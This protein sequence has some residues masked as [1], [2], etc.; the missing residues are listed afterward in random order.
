[1][2]RLVALSLVCVMALSG[3]GT[4]ESIETEGTTEAE[5]NGEV[6]VNSEGIYEIDGVLY[7][8][9]YPLDEKSAYALGEKI[10]SVCDEYLTENNRVFVSL[11]PDKSC[12]SQYDEKIDH[13]EMAEKVK[14]SLLHGE[15]IEIAD[16]LKISDYYNTDAHWK[17]EEIFDTAGKLGEVMGFEVKR[18]G[19]TE[20]KK[21]DYLGMYA[22]LFEGEVQRE[23]LTYL[24]NEYTESARVDNFQKPDFKAVYDTELLDSKTPYDVFLSGPTPFTVIENPK[25]DFKRELVIF[26]DS[27]ASSLAPLMIESYSRI[28]LI[29]LRYMAA[30]LL[31]DFIEFDSQ[32]VLFLYSDAVANRSILL[33]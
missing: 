13:Y 18:D 5:N 25:A 21:T 28:T 2:K 20:K 9:L 3:C 8:K 11:I 10:N 6:T 4:G 23:K 14:N 19:F 24:V 15:Y 33:K 29:D 27:F 22:P 12:F 31:P 1:M 7:S 17:Q 26:R 16:T 32:D 30:K